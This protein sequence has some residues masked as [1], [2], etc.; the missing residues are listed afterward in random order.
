MTLPINSAGSLN[1]VKFASIHDSIIEPQYYNQMIQ[2][3]PD[4]YST[5]YDFLMM[6]GSDIAVKDD[7]YRVFYD[8]WKWEY[9]TVKSNVADAGAGNAATITLSAGDHNSDGT[10]FPR[11][12]QSVKISKGGGKIVHCR[13]MDKDDTTDPAAHT[14]TIRPSVD[15]ETIGAITAGTKIAFGA[16]TAAYG[17]GQPNGLYSGEIERQYGM[18]IFEETFEIEGHLIPKPTWVYLESA[19]GGKGGYLAKEIADTEFRLMKGKGLDL[20]FSQEDDNA[21]F[22]M[23]SGEQSV[24][25]GRTGAAIPNT[26]G[27]WHWAY[28]LG[29]TDPIAV[30]GFT[31][32]TFDDMKQH[33]INEGISSGTVMIMGGHTRI[34][35]ISNVIQS[36]NAA[37]GT[38]Y[39][40]GV[41]ED[42]Q[43]FRKD[44]YGFYTRGGWD[45]TFD[46]KSVTRGNIKFVLL[47]INDFSD[48]KT[49]GLSDYGFNNN[50]IAFPVGVERVATTMG[51]SKIWTP[52]VSIMHIA[53]NGYSRKSEIWA[54]GGANGTYNTNL[55]KVAYNYRC[56]EGMLAMRANQY[57]LGVEPA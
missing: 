17:S 33:L 10:S 28:E 1:N 27:L 22:V 3:H 15:T 50:F 38:D 14:I 9:I 23:G 49:L 21:S 39:T 5:F 56:H 51:G 31:M 25:G 47:E 46:F 32:S 43:K 24:F 57:Y 42:A 18:S 11:I 41:I 30:G 19:N 2:E 40:R 55:D 12:G 8:G 52:N 37:N 29:T 36:E 45:A 16:I 44:K 34:Q 35:E 54:I 13:I 26:K 7:P 48:P 6:M 4:Q 20:M 53:N